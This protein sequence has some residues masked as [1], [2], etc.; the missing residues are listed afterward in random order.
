VILTSSREAEDMIK[1]I[2]SRATSYVRKP[3]IFTDFA[4]VVSQLGLYWMLL[5]QM[6][7]NRPGG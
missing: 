7:Q 5:N 1:S 3:V 6:P 2:N 4:A